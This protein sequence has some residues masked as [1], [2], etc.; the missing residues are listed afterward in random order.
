MTMT[1]TMDVCDII[2]KQVKK[3]HASYVINIIQSYFKRDILIRY[4]TQWMC[5]CSCS[6]N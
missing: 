1:M 2:E 3:E 6:S 4:L 5:M